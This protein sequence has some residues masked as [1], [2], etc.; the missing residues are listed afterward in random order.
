MNCVGEGDATAAADLPR[1]PTQQERFA[2]GLAIERKALGF[3]GLR[4][5]RITFGELREGSQCRLLT[6]FFEDQFLRA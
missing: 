4:E 5:S 3:A 2:A 1:C 6:K